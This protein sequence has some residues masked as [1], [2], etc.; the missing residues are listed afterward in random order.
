M[1]VIDAITRSLSL[2]SLHL[3]GRQHGSN[4]AGGGITGQS[5]D[6]EDDDEV[7]GAA[8]SSGSKAL[9]GTADAMAAH[10]NGTKEDAGTTDS[11][12]DSADDIL[13]CAALTNRLQCMK[14]MC[15]ISHSCRP[16][17]PRSLLVLQVKGHLQPNS[18]CQAEL[19]VIPKY[20]NQQG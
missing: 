11:G 18:S 4:G 12:P 3:Q 5:T 10:L 2:L 17:P 9:N 20:V 19:H 8:G 7:D 6:D 1:S 15:L 16:Q 13:E 14:I